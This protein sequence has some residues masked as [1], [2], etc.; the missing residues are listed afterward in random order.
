MPV[1]KKLLKLTKHQREVLQNLDW[2]GD[3]GEV[4]YHDVRGPTAD[5]LLNLGLVQE[6]RAVPCQTHG[7]AHPGYLGLTELGRRVLAA[8]PTDYVCSVC[9]SAEVQHA[10]WVTLNTEQV[11]GEFGTWN[12]DDNTWCPDCCDAGRDGHTKIILREEYE[13]ACRGAKP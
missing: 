1:I 4:W 8:K 7:R 11:R 5:R 12:Y 6:V 10:M 2:L 13:K 9:G 3:G